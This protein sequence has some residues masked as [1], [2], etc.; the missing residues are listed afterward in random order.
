M[1]FSHEKKFIFFHL[2]KV[3]GSSIKAALEEYHDFPDVEERYDWPHL[4][5]RRFTHLNLDADEKWHQRSDEFKKIY[6]EYYTFAFVRNPYDW[7]ISFYEYVLIHPEHKRHEEIKATNFEGFVEWAPHHL[8][9]QYKWL[10]GGGIDEKEMHHKDAILAANPS[11]PGPITLDFV[12]RFESL[13]DDFEKITKHLG[14]EA[15]LPHNNKSERKAFEEY[16]S[17]K[18]ILNKVREDFS[19]DFEYFNYD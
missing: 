3:A 8:P 11:V 15:S 18:R 5:P 12:G 13:D 17:D 7:L 19:M 9:T 2:F 1:I 4:Y 14:I 16:Y 6:D 10:S